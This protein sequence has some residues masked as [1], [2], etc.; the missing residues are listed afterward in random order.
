MSEMITIK[1]KLLKWCPYEFSVRFG[2]SDSSSI[3]LYVGMGG[4]W[5]RFKNGD[6]LLARGAI[7]DVN[8]KDYEKACIDS[9]CEINDRKITY[10]KK[11]S[12]G[13][14]AHWKEKTRG[15]GTMSGTI[16]VKCDLRPHEDAYRVEVS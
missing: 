3:Q 8:A 9:I 14:F 11:D 15:G 4:V 13:V 1:A 10:I 16:K 6:G 12:R 5:A 7:V 2:R